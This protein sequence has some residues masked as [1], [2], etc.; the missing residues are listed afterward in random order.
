MERRFAM[1]S[2][3]IEEFV[4]TKAGEPYRLFPFGKIVKN[5]HVR[6]ITP[7][8]AATIKLPHFKPAIK[9]GSHEDATPAGGHIIGLEVRADGLYAIP[10]FNDKGAQALHEGAY[11]YHSPEIIWEGGLEDP[12]G[13]V[14]SAPLIVGDALLHAPHLGEATA[15]Y[16]VEEIKQQEQSMDNMTIPAS[17]WDKFIAPLLERKPE[18]KT[19]TVEIV[20]EPEDYGALKSEVEQYRAEAARMKAEAERKERIT[21]FTAELTEAKVDPTLADLLADLDPEKAD[22][23]LRQFKALSARADL[24][25]EKGTPSDGSTGDPKAEFNAVVLSLMKSDNIT[26]YNAAFELAKQKN[27]DLF[28]LAFK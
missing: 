15:M 22:A 11:R 12:Q 25:A 6:T 8:F 26:N 2:I 7:E 21:K 9:L 24:P 1:H 27:A 16:S 14:I 20:K 28:K 5:G 17:L 3:L 10:E 18:V 19:E 4:N 23:V 13:G